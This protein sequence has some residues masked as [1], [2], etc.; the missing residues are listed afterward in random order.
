M[1]AADA[2]E[3]AEFP[4]TAHSV[5]EEDGETVPSVMEIRLIA[6]IPAAVADRLFV[7]VAMAEMRTALIAAALAMLNASAAPVQ[8]LLFASAAAAAAMSPAH[9]AEKAGSTIGPALIVV[10]PAA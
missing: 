4:T 7:R 2:A 8:G 9:S 3:R 10:V 6:V 5:E 1:S